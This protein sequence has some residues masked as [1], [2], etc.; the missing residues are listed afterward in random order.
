MGMEILDHVSRENLRTDVPK[1][2]AGDTIKVMVR[3]H[4]KATRSGCRRT[5]AS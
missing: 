1:F 5:K 2:D 4:V 3:V